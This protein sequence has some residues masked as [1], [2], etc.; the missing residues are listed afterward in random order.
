V[1]CRALA[2]LGIVLAVFAPATSLAQQK[3]KV[4]HIGFLRAEAPDFLLDAFRDGLRELGYVEGQTVVIE[5]RW[6]YGRFEKLPEMANELVR[7]KVD[8]IVTASTPAVLAVKRATSTIPVVIA[9]SGDPVAN[10]FVTSLAHP[11]GNITGLTIMIEELAVKRLEI[12]KECVPRASRVAVLWSAANPSYASIVKNIEGAA[13]RVKLQPELIKVFGPDQ[14]DSALA[15]VARSHADALYVFEDP[16]FRSNSKPIS[17]FAAKHRLP[18][19]YGG[20]EFVHDG[21]LLSYGPSFA[22]MFRRAAGYVDKILKGAKPADLPIEQLSKFELAVNLRTARALGL[23]I[24][25][26]IL[27]RAD[28]VVR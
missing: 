27:V 9:A 8:V 28:E 12:L 17:D 5:Q 10:G 11:G 1:I 18:T 22:E 26:S 21:G 6:A 13:P 3:P 24:P 20:S 4:P 15:E 2:L 16:V 14:V 23:T 25:E 19:I 7:M